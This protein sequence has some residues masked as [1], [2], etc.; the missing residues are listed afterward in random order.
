MLISKGNLAKGAFTN[1]IRS[2]S[3]SSMKCNSRPP[4]DA[5]LNG[6]WSLA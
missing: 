1:S 4:P 6:T 3:L 5:Y 2:I